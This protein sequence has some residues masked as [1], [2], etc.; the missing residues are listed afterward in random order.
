M[1]VCYGKIPPP[2]AAKTHFDDNSTMHFRLLSFLLLLASVCSAVASEHWWFLP[3]YQYDIRGV[4]KQPV[5]EEPF[6]ESLPKEAE[7]LTHEESG[8]TEAQRQELF[9]YGA[10]FPHGD[11]ESTY[12]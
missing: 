3:N 8:L 1:F 7:R 4:E 2:I 9:W 5:C 11:K 6:F 12:E 10:R